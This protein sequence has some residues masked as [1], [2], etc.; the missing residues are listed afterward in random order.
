MNKKCG[1]CGTEL[2]EKN[3]RTT[4]VK[5]IIAGFV[6][7][8]LLLWLAHE[9]IMPYLSFLFMEIAGIIMMK[10]QNVHYFCPDC[11]AT[12][13]PENNQDT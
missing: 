9:T 6:V 5:L 2:K 11:K 13:M 1:Q 10:K 7:F 8:P 3:S 4:G 12:E